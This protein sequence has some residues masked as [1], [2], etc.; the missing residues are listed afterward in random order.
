M[1][2]ETK[3]VT[4]FNEFIG[5]YKA[6]LKSMF[7]S[8]LLFALPLIIVTTVIIVLQSYYGG[9]IF[10]TLLPVLLLMPLYGGLTQVTKDLIIKSEIHPYKNFIKG[11]KS[12]FRQMVILGI[13]M[14]LLS[15]IQFFAL[16]FY[17]SVA[18][19]NPIIYA[20]FA[21]AIITV[22]LIISI[23]YY[24]PLI[25]VTVDLKMIKSLKNAFLMGLYEI[26]NNIKI[27]F[28]LIFLTMVSLTA[29]II[30]NNFLIGMIVLVILI[31]LL[32]PIT[33]SL[34]ISMLAY[35]KIDKMLIKPS[36]PVNPK[37]KVETTIKEEVTK[38]V[39]L[40]KE[41]I[42]NSK[43]DDYIFLNGRMIKKSVAQKY[44]EDE[45]AI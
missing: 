24:L 4:F 18:Q 16:I 10:I 15:L 12:N 9:N 38:N 22:L 30:P 29:F 1:A 23:F 19:T 2:R 33:V 6:N 39:T 44:L 28:S 43:N 37:P 20:V 21:V 41:I 36:I 26:P 42:D 34:I 8:N 35:P 3:K 25:I 11:V 32:L 27:F 40:T 7:I 5:Y 13:I 45:E 31:L 17:Y 14:Y